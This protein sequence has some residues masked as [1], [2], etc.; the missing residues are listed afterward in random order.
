LLKY[1]GKFLQNSALQLSIADELNSMKNDEEIF[2]LVKNN[3]AKKINIQKEL[4]LSET[5]LN[6]FDLILISLKSWNEIR[7]INSDW[8]TN[9][10][11]ILIINK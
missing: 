4:N 7:D 1:A 3:P 5:F 8:I 6:Q 2:N 11:S 10:P 9:S